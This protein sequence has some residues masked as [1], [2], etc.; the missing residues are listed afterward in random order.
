[1]QSHS[2]FHVKQPIKLTSDKWPILKFHNILHK[3]KKNIIV[4]AT[5]EF[6]NHLII[7]YNMMDI[8]FR[9]SALFINR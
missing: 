9:I 5:S 2:D 7:L 4:N 1:M 8:H 3:K 6:M